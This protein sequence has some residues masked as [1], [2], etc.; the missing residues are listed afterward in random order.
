MASVLAGRAECRVVVTRPDLR[1]A[2]EK[3]GAA[4]VVDPGEFWADTGEFWVD[5]LPDLGRERLPTSRVPD[6][7]IFVDHLPRTRASRSPRTHAHD[8]D[9]EE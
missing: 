9:T 3:A 2:V 1:G 8:T 7:V 5:E 4:P 6:E